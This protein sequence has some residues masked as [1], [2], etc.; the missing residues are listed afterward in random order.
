MSDI[1]QIALNGVTYN[2]KDN[3]ARTETA[4]KVT[5]SG[6][7]TANTKIA[8]STT[9]TE[10]FPVPVAGDTHKVILGKIIKF[11]SDFK[12]LK[13]GLVTIGMMSNQNINDQNKVPT[14]AL[15]YSVKQQ[16]DKANSDL[17][18]KADINTLPKTVHTSIT[19][20]GSDYYDISCPGIKYGA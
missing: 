19:G 13:D 14:S 20:T 12:A 16:V 5:A 15:L 10:A 11:F 3:T 4:M 1:S 6:G 2:I 7:D 9:S 18:G 17:A 8:S